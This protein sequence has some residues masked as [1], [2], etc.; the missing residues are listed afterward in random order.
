MISNEV[1]SSYKK[2]GYAVIP[3]FLTAAEVQELKNEVTRILSKVDL[4]NAHTGKVK[5]LNGTILLVRH[6]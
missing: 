5:E 3:D 6:G 2:N 1:V 4:N